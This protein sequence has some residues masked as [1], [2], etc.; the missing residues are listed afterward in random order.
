MLPIHS[1]GVDLRLSTK[2]HEVLI[3]DHIKW[4]QI[5]VSKLKNV[6]I[7]I[8]T[9]LEA[10]LKIK[11]FRIHFTVNYSDAAQKLKLNLSKNFIWIKRITNFFH[12]FRIQCLHDKNFSHET[13]F[14]SVDLLVKMEF[15][16]VYSNQDN[17]EMFDG[18]KGPGVSGPWGR[19]I[20][21]FCFLGAWRPILRTVERL[22][23]VSG[24]GFHPVK[25]WPRAVDK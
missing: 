25:L 16:M 4:V 11:L 21:Y 6:F 12:N 15:D 19:P 18:R 9:Y 5:H 13:M 20:L 2:Y 10:Q 22:Y 14:K 8:N 3:L 7:V 17:F 1:C 23:Y 24:I